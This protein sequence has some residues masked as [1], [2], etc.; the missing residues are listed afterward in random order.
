MEWTQEQRYRKLEEVSEAELNQLASKVAGCPWRQHFHIQPKTGLLNDPNG[1]SY[2]KGAYHLFYQWFPLGPV[3][4]LKY[5][6]HLTS[7]DLI[8]WEDAGIGI[9]PDREFDSHGAYS[10]SGIVHHDKLHLLYTGNH[11]TKDWERIPTQGLAVLDKDGTITKEEHPVIG[12]V[13]SGYTDHYRDPKV[14]RSGDQF[15]MVVGAQRSNETGTATIYQ[16]ADLKSWTFRGELETNYKAFGYMW[17]CPDYFELDHQGVFLFS[18]QGIEPDGNR[19]RNIYQSG[20]FLGKP[21]NLDTL[22]FEHGAFQELDHGFDFYAPQTMESP[23]GKRMV[24]GWMGL[25]DIEYPSDRHG[26]AHC[27]TLPRELSIKNGKLYQQPVASVRNLQKTSQIFEISLTSEQHLVGNGE[28]YEL[29]ATFVNQGA[30]RFG[31]NLR[32]GDGEKTV[33]AYTPQQGELTLDRSLSGEPFAEEFGVTRTVNLLS[34]QL[35][36]R[37][38]VDSSS[39]EIFVNDGEFVLTSRIFPTNHENRIEVFAEGGGALANLKI[40]R[41]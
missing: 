20:Y 19:Y 39:V 25:P 15:Y 16:S 28:C 9:A 38:F 7:T 29:E 40:W 41:Y 36:V 13:P 23:D 1:F 17:E 32:A 2:F 10:G 22:T 14:W 31:L 5:W 30:T 21:L 35:K 18:P 24:I 26:W 12:T 27:L 8:N 6:Y 33:L 34:E 37:I 4:G 11:R 3:H